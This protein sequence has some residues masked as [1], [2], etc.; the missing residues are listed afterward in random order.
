LDLKSGVYLSKQQIK[1]DKD[2]RRGWAV[3]R[4]IIGVDDLETPGVFYLHNR[5]SHARSTS[6][7]E[8]NTIIKVMY[9]YCLS[10]TPL[11]NNGSYHNTALRIVCGCY[12]VARKAYRISYPSPQN[13]MGW[14]LLT[15]QYHTNRKV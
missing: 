4:Y 6:G 10:V 7:V 2:K 13:K 8:N 5:L 9:S 3:K 12:A 15:Y 11:K 1:I 14:T